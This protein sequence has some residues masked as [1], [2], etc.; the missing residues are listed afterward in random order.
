MSPS[1]IGASLG[2]SVPRRLKADEP[3]LKVHPRP[4]NRLQISKRTPVSQPVT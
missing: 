4:I 1:R 3:S 2:L